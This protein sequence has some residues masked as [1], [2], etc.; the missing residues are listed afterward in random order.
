MKSRFPYVS[1][2]GQ[3]RI[4][5]PKQF[6][7]DVCHRGPMLVFDFCFFP[8]NYECLSLLC[9]IISVALRVIL[10]CYWSEYSCGAGA[11]TERRVRNLHNSNVREL[12]MSLCHDGARQ[13]C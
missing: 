9:L 13:P 10:A 4:K 6:F 7:V 5:A 2:H 3:K 1:Y 12:D 8:L 11:L